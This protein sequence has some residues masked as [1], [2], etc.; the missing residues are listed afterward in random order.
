MIFKDSLLPCV[1]MGFEFTDAN[2]KTE[3]AKGF[4]V[5]D[6]FA[7]WC[8]PCRMMAPIFEEVEKQ[9]A[10]KVKMGKINVDDSP[11]TPGSFG[12]SSISRDE[13]TL[14]RAMI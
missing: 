13:L 4:S 12:V 6:M 7:D 5:V 11:A 14:L 1:R 8:G 10:G 2:F 3:T 9:F